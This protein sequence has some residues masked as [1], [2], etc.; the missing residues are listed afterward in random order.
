[1]DK[2]QVE[3]LNNYETVL[4]MAAVEIFNEIV[5]RS[6][7]MDFSERAVTINQAVSTVH[8]IIA[9]VLKITR[10]AE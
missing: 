5:T 8:E 6:G 2:K 4:A 3:D 9:R 7:G 1:M 10:S